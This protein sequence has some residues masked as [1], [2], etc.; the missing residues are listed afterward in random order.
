M[1]DLAAPK[2]ITMALKMQNAAAPDAAAE[3]LPAGGKK[4]M[5]I[6]PIILAV[7]VLAGSGA[8]FA[9]FKMKHGKHSNVP[10]VLKVG[11]VV[12][13]DEFMLNLA[14]PSDDHY[15]KTTLA[16]GLK[17]G[18]SAD[19]FKDKV[20]ETRDAILMVLTSKHLDQL[21]SVAGKTALKKQLIVK[22]NQALGEQDVVAVYFQEFATQ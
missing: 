11:E 8:G 1:D 3:P 12:P 22:I 5:P 14:D 18:F 7:V 2:D 13:L 15:L 20:P 10:V 21:R 17:E 19:Q 6:L 9:V 4:K 16:L